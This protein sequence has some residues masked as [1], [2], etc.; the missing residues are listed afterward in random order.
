MNLKRTAKI[1][2]STFPL[3]LAA[4]AVGQAAGAPSVLV[5][6][7]ALKKAPLLSTLTCY[8]EVKADARRTVNI[9]FP[10]AG[11][12]S[13]LMV[14]AG[15]VVKKG[16]PLLEFRTAPADALEY[17]KAQAAL[18]YARDEVQRTEKMVAKHLA[19]NAQLASARR[20][21]AGAQ[22]LLK[23]QRKLGRSLEIE[24][25]LAPFD[26]IVT[27]LN[28]K[29]GDRTQAG[30]TLLQLARK[31]A[32]RAELGVEP[33]DVHRVAV[34]MPVSIASVFDAGQT[35]KGHVTE[36]HGVINPQTRLVDVLAAMTSGNLAHFLP[37]MQVKGKITLRTGTYWLLPRSAVLSDRQ[38]AYIFQVEG[39]R[40]HRVNV[41]IEQQT[42]RQ[43][44]IEGDFD[45]HLKVVTEGNYEL[46]DGM[47]VREER[48]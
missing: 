21:L 45:P 18:D 8:G 22:A 36:V 6:T 47:A 23:A 26:G 16:A 1:F 34:D 12:V 25:A 20:D 19:T 11:E 43:V 40:A 27:A 41:R 35:A 38:G 30:T 17:R 2:L 9:G 15:E 5:R 32:L 7:E 24:R 4:A 31:G 14:S 13:R 37:G 3:F 44:A 33:E 46:K 42:D 29:E 48:P 10:R 28:V 39:G